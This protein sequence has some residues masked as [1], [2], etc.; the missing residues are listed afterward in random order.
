MLK[1][2]FQAHPLSKML[3]DAWPAEAP[4]AENRER[5]EGIAPAHREEILRAAAQY[6]KQPYPMRPASA[7]LAF[8]DDGSRQADEK[9]YFF[10]RRKLCLAAL[11]C[12]LEEGADAEADLMAAVDGIWCIC[13]E[14]SWVISAHCVNPIPGAPGTAE[15]RLPDPDQPYIDLFSAQTGMILA[16]VKRL[17]GARLD[18]VSPLLAKRISREIKIRILDPFQ[19]TDDFWWMGVRRKDLNN[20]TPWILSNVMLCACTELRGE[21][22]REELAA[23][24][25][26]GCAMLDRWLAVLPADGGCDEGAGYWNMA[27]G[28]LLDCLELLERMTGGQVQLW[29]QEKLRNVLTFPRK[30][31]IGNGWFI[32]F[33]D[34]DA[35]PSLSAE[36]VRM[37]GEKL[38]DAGMLALWRRMTGE[39]GESALAEISDTPHF[40]RTLATLFHPLPGPDAGE[41]KDAP[42]PDT[43]LPDLQVRMVRRGRMILCAKGGH[44]GENHNHNDVGSFMLY[45]DGEPVIVDAGNMVYTAKT[46]SDERYTLWNVRSAWHN[47]PLIGGVEQAA[48]EGFAARAV[49]CLP[50]GLSL[51]LA[52]AYPKEAGVKRLRRTL[53]L[54]EEALTV[55]DE[56]SLER[57]QPVTWTMLLRQPPT[58]AED[59]I[60]IGPAELRPPEGLRFEAET[61]PVTDPRMARNFPGELYR[62][63][64]TGTLREGSYTFRV[65]LRQGDGKAKGQEE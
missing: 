54:T 52:G 62:V 15:Q 46:F 2:Y 3:R 64:L 63:R 6:R 42:L 65:A 58:P 21:A 11:A 47:V 4:P 41:E 34:C 25:E 1:E 50:D 61:K 27:G 16:L 8:T 39:R 7:F 35:R 19:A 5:W 56:L 10:R 17:L 20:W 59:A 12:C 32:N 24:L 22:C 13:E 40:S 33:A 57:E 45:V 29:E 31:E 36:R 23:F 48:G 18:A 30:A 44:N 14:S 55:T 43:W 9:P 38:G 37:A 26:R 51:E 28:S 53:R 49:S 60:W